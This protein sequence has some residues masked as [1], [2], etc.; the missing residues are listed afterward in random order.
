MLVRHQRRQELPSGQDFGG[1]L[2]FCPCIP[3]GVP[4]GPG[5]GMLGPIIPKHKISFALFYILKLNNINV[6]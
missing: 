6:C 3:I 2:G 4:D 5:G 1:P